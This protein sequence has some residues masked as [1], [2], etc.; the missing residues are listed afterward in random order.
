MFLWFDAIPMAWI[1]RTL[2]GGSTGNEHLTAVVAAVL[3]LLLA[4]EGATLLRLQPLLTVHAFV[5]MLLIP[6]VALK[7][8]STGWRMLRYYGGG[9]EYVSRGP[10]PL[11]LRALVAPV[12]ILSTLVLFAT[13]TAL[14]VSRSDRR[15]SRRPAQGELHRLV[16]GGCRPRTGARLE[17]ASPS[18]GHRAAGL[19]LRDSSRHRCRRSWSL[20][21]PIATLPAADRLQDQ[22]VSSCPPRRRLGA[23][24]GVPVHVGQCSG[25]TPDGYRERLS[26]RAGVTSTAA[27]LAGTARPSHIPAPDRMSPSRRSRRSALRAPTPGSALPDLR[28]RRPSGSRTAYRQLPRRRAPSR[29]ASGRSPR[30]GGVA[31]R[32]RRAACTRRPRTRNAS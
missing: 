18:C 11:I 13:G 14:L 22:R 1:R 6:V 26:P 15:D 21:S 23:A 7:L 20:L 4:M 30:L 25:M 31:P 5:G 9:A 2:T 24:H 17:A 16:R 12:L 10:P 8:A 19:G 3:L 27:A 32:P 28:G 29:E